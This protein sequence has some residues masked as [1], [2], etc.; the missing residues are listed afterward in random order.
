MLKCHD[1]KISDLDVLN[2][3]ADIGAAK[4]TVFHLNLATCEYMNN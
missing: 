2:R 3:K 4:N 1:A